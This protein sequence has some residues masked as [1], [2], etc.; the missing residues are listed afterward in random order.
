MQ[1]ESYSSVGKGNTVTSA[2]T[3]GVAWELPEQFSSII[4]IPN[5]SYLHAQLIEDKTSC[6][7]KEAMPFPVEFYDT[8][9]VVMSYCIGDKQEG[10]DSEKPYDGTERR[11]HIALRFQRN[12]KHGFGIMGHSGN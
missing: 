6:V 8:I 11:K 1:A 10:H 4:K 5:I 3:E 12:R 2:N 9:F 7:V